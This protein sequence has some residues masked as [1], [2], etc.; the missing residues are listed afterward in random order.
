MHHNNPRVE[1][2]LTARLVRLSHALRPLAG[3]HPDAGVPLT[4]N[5][6]CLS[7]HRVTLTLVPAEWEEAMATTP[8]NFEALASTSHEG[9]KL[10][11]SGLCDPCRQV[12]IT[13]GFD[14]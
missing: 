13:E 14:A 3:Q 2:F 5:T 9:R 1:Q 12:A 7:G 6:Q 4:V 10:L 11:E 8:P